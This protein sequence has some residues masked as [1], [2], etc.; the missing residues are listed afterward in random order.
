ML[1]FWK[2]EMRPSSPF[3]PEIEAIPELFQPIS[4]SPFPEVTLAEIFN[5]QADL[6]ES[7]SCSYRY[8]GGVEIEFFAPAVAFW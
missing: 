7:G 5:F 1:G 2:M 4:I 6:A 3:F 8:Y